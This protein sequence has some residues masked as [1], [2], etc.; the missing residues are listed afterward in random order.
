MRIGRNHHLDAALLGEAQM[1][2]AQIEDERV[3]IGQEGEGSSE[4]VVGHGVR[5]HSVPGNVAMLPSRI[6]TSG[7]AAFSP[8][9][10]EHLGK[11]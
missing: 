4:C 8:H 1:R 6:L 3:R 10:R 2:V 5:Q 11:G 7:T 9:L